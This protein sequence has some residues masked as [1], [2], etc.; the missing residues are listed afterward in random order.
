M[1]I[2]TTTISKA[3]ELDL[4][5]II[6]DDKAS[7][8]SDK[9]NI[10]NDTEIVETNINGYT[11]YEYSLEYYDSEYK[12]NFYANIIWIETQENVYILNFEVVTK[13]TEKIKPIFDSIKSS[14][15]FN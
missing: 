6:K 14:I 4:L 15:K 8:L 5:N 1:Y 13:N 11:G 9:E 3:R 7:Y 2:Y 10:I 12:D